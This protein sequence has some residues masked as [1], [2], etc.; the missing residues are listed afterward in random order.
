M[1]LGSAALNSYQFAFHA[2]TWPV[3][4]LPH[5]AFDG[6]TALA[7]G[8]AAWRVTP[9]HRRTLLVWGRYR[10][11]Y[12]PLPNS[13]LTGRFY[14]PRSAVALALTLPHPLLPAWT[15]YGTASGPANDAHCNSGSRLAVTQRQRFL[16]LA[17][18]L[19]REFHHTHCCRSSSSDHA[20][21][22]RL[23]VAWTFHA[24]G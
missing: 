10:L 18:G 24:A 23:L 7:P 15:V 13:G 5:I 16:I 12:F 8:L 19:Q 2:T 21:Q 9:C 14:C 6:W 22:H 4:Y 11:G 17:V 20:C 1:T 3:D